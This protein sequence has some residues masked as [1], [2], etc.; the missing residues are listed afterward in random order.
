MFHP[1]VNN[2]YFYQNSLFTNKL[3]VLITWVVLMIFIS[4]LVCLIY[5]IKPIAV[6]V[7]FGDDSEGIAPTAI[8]HPFCHFFHDLQPKLLF[9]V[10]L[11]FI[12]KLILLK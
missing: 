9:Y 11:S 5:W 6:S 2:S 4:T 10:I 3:R 8:K 12:N 7:F 1:T